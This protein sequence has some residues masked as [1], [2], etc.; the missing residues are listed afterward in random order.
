M[1]QATVASKD[2]DTYVLARD[3]WFGRVVGRLPSATT[4]D[5]ALSIR[6]ELEP[7]DVRDGEALSV[8]FLIE[9]YFG[10]Q[11]FEGVVLDA[12]GAVVRRHVWNILPNGSILDATADLHGVTRI[13]VLEAEDYRRYRAEWTAIYNPGNTAEFPELVGCA[14]TGL[15]D[16]ELMTDLPET[17]LARASPRY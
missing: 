10:W 11:M 15:I 6:R 14:W 3:A 4:I 12:D 7:E 16:A 1:R 8:A 9:K 17:S 2:P 13:G 5:D